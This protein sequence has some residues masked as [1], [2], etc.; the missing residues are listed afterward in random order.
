ML[1]ARACMSVFESIKEVSS[2]NKILNS[3]VYIGNSLI[4]IRNNRG[5]RI[6]PCGT[7]SIIVRRELEMSSIVTNCF[8][9]DK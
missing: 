5:P 8:R 7:P 2:A 6:D 4:Y 3:D 9:L 1:V